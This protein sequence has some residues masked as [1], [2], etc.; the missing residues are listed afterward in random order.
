MLSAL[1]TFEFLFIVDILIHRR[2][3][4]VIFCIIIIPQS[5]YFPLMW[6]Q[7][8]S[9]LPLQFGACWYFCT[10]MEPPAKYINVECM[11]RKKQTEF[12]SQLKITFILK[13]KRIIRLNF[14]AV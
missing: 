11:Y 9:Y 6:K 8:I 7:K 14:I 5:F 13:E 2:Q 3:A 4:N 10:R 12:T 1:S